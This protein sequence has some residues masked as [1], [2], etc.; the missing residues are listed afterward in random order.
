MNLAVK[1]KCFRGFGLGRARVG[2]GR[3][4]GYDLLDKDKHLE[5]N[6]ECGSMGN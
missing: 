4:Q 3:E 6:I 1:L 2:G 5:G